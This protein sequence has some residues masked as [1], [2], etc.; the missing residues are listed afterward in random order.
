MCKGGKKIFTIILSSVFYFFTKHTATALY[1]PSISGSSSTYL[2]KYDEKETQRDQASASWTCKGDTLEPNQLIYMEEFIC[3][4]VYRFGLEELYR[5]GLVRKSPNFLNVALIINDDIVEVAEIEM[6]NYDSRKYYM[7]MERN[8]NLAVY[9]D[10]EIANQAQ[11]ELWSSNTNGNINATLKIDEYGVVR[12]ISNL[13]T[14]W[15][16]KPVMKYDCDADNLDTSYTVE[17]EIYICNENYR[18]GL[19]K[20][21]DLGLWKD[22]ELL[23]LLYEGNGQKSKMTMRNDGNLVV[24]LSDEASTPLWTSKTDGN[25]GT[26]LVLNSEGVVMIQSFLGKSLWSVGDKKDDCNG[27]RLVPGEVLMGE[28]YICSGSHKFGLGPNFSVSHYVN[29]KRFELSKGEG[30]DSYMVMQFDGNLVVYE[31]GIKKWDTNTD[32]NWGSSLFIDNNGFVSIVS[33]NGKIIWS[34]D[35]KGEYDCNGTSLGATQSLNA[36]NFICNGGSSGV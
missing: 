35:I 24:Y 30:L 29:G 6:H 9:N 7:I 22:D 11:E 20:N 13:E 36:G 10:I 8:G 31:H 3:N 12:I 33:E 14:V 21:S 1:D 34:T 26:Q 28:N 16:P 32:G 17:N 25:Y 19:N 23:V 27:S 5:F 18:F 2:G 15:N 4:G